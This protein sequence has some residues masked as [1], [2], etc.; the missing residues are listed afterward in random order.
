MNV[1]LETSRLV[2]RELVPDDLDFVAEMLADSGVMR[3]YPKTYER[4]ESQVCMGR[5]IEKYTQEGHGLWLT[6][7][8][9][10]LE[11]VGLV[12]L[13]LQEVEGES[14]HEIGYLIHQPYWRRGYATEAALGVRRHA[15]EV[16]D[17][18]RVVSLVR[19]ENVPSV[20]VAK[21]L[22]MTPEREVCFYGFRHLVYGV[23]AE[24]VRTAERAA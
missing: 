6:S 1:I 3:Y 16:Y 7:L 20:A 21:K 4:S 2:L 24:A 15:F 19:P 11:P 8:R 18:P 23:A 10:S 12:G 5:Q 22:G 17:L 13:V 9:D 14:F